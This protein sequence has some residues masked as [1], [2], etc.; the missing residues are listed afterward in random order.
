MGTQSWGMQLFFSTIVVCTNVLF[1]Q[2]KETLE[3]DFANCCS[4]VH[5]ERPC[6]KARSR[7]FRIDLLLRFTFEFSFKNLYRN[8]NKA[9]D[10]MTVHNVHTS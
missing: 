6:L 5:T 9:E 10:F 1:A 3:I 7:Y 4:F 8:K 2:F